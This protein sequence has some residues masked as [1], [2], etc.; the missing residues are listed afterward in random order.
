[1]EGYR[2]GASRDGGASQGAKEEIRLARQGLGRARTHL[3]T[4][5]SQAG[6]ELLQWEGMKGREMG[7]T[8]KRGQPPRDWLSSGD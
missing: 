2:R 5:R 6:N 7:P 8:M 4:A 3:L 1:M